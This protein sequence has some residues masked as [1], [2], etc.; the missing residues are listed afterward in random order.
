MENLFLNSRGEA[1]KVND[2][3]S[4]ADW[5]PVQSSGKTAAKR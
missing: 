3:P 4:F 5:V 2:R 1:W